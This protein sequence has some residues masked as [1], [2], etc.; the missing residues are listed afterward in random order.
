MDVLSTSEIKMELKFGT[1]VHQTIGPIQIKID[2]KLEPGTSS[3]PQSPKSGP[4]V[5]GC[6]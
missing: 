3:I 4:K 2:A 1:W 5:H 6:S